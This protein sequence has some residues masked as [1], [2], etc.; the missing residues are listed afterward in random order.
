MQIYDNKVSYLTFGSQK[1]GVI[2]TDPLI[3]HMHRM[4]FDFAWNSPQAYIPA[5]R[6]AASDE[7]SRSNAV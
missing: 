4:L 2:I 5:S 7:G 6:G 3:A 1:I